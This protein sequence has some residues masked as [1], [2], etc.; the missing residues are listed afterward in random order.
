MLT[1]GEEGIEKKGARFDPIGPKI[2]GYLVLSSLQ[3]PVSF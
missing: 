1:P 2:I 3:I